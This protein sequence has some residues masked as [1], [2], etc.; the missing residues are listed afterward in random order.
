MPT[1]PYDDLIAAPGAVAAG[2]P[3]KNPYDDIIVDEQA[4]LQT[5]LRASVGLAAES[6]PQAVAAQRQLAKYA[7]FAPA[8]GEAL[9]NE[10]K[11]M[12]TVKRVATDTA[13]QPVLQKAYSNEEFARIGHD[14][15]SALS[16]LAWSALGACLG[17]ATF[18]Q[19]TSFP[20]PKK[21]TSSSP[22]A[23]ITRR[24]SLLAWAKT[25]FMTKPERKTKRDRLSV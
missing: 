16:A 6:N 2:G 11:Q 1:N 12:A 9:P 3:P 22:S 23:K 14:D 5:Q 7:G 24:L 18:P 25:G 15:S 10:V 21:A 8:V 20:L 17:M 19:P 13:G 4:R